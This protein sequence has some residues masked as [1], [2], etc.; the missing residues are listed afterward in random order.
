MPVTDLREWLSRLDRPEELRRVS[1]HS[2]QAGIVA[3]QC[4][5]G[6]YA[7]KCVIV[8][9]DDVEITSINEV[10][11]AALTRCDPADDL[12]ILRKCWSTRLDP[13]SYPP[14]KGF[15]NNRV[16]IDACRP[17][18]QRE[19][20]PPVVGPSRELVAKVKARWPDLVGP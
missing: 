6:A 8:V 7:N 12:E 20:F 15:F 1:G 10:L 18:E 16:V 5:G 11:W 13:T 4:H 17:W 2:R 14:G 9:D 3:S 19:S